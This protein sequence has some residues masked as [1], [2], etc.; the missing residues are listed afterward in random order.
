MSEVR[1]PVH[2]YYERYLRHFPNWEDLV[3]LAFDDENKDHPLIEKA[4][5]EAKRRS[6]LMA[7][8]YGEIDGTNPSK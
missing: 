8:P 2:P 1:F 5:R 4:R 6:D 3:R 7:L